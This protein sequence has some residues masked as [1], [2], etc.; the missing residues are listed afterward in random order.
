MRDTAREQGCPEPTF[1]ED[2]FFTA[3]FFPNPEVR[4]HVTPPAE[5]TAE[6]TAEVLRLLSVSEGEMMRRDLM[7][8]L[9]LTHQEHFRKAYLLPALNAGWIERALP[10]KPRSSKQRYRLTARGKEILKQQGEGGS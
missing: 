3:V 8:A 4:A 7:D 2:G 9:G 5:V 1:T 10:G 6:V